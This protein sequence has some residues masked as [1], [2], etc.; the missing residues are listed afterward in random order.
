ML[1]KKKLQVEQE[2]VERQKKLEEQKL[3]REQ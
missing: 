1:E 3:L 2:E